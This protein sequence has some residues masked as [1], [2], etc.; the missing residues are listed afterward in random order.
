MGSAWKDANA[1]ARQ[2]VAETGAVYFHPFA[3][4]D[5]VAGQG[6]LAL[7]I[8]DQ[9]PDVETILVAMGGGGLVSGIAT[10]V[11]A[12]APAV[13]VIGIEAAGSPVLLRSLEA[14]RNVSL[15]RVTTR[16]ATMSG[17]RTDDRIF[18][19]VRY[20]VD[21]IVLVSDD[22]MQS[23]AHWLWFEMGLAADQV[24]PRPSPPCARTASAPRPANASANRVRRRPRRHR[25]V[26]RSAETAAFQI[27]RSQDAACFEKVR[28]SDGMELNALM[29]IGCSPEP[30]PAMTTSA[31]ARSYTTLGSLTDY[32]IER[33]FVVQPLSPDA[34]VART[35]G[36]I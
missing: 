14:G 25:G 20:H 13:R 1:A 22:E 9:V 27:P 10:A 11:K 12:V 28:W 34:Q 23:A 35:A 15:D 3:D 36:R 4:P 30:E 7:E 26:S 5:V 2:W 31:A 8:L 32:F 21:E 18:E 19:M 16:V 17:A 29:T 6:T 33:P 24:A